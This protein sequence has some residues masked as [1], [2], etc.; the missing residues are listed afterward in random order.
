MAKLP[1]IMPPNGHIWA[2]VRTLDCYER[3]AVCLRLEGR[4]ANDP[5]QE[6]DERFVPEGL[7]GRNPGWQGR[8]Q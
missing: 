8:P 5:W 1:D 7:K 2:C 6:G 3:C 4:R